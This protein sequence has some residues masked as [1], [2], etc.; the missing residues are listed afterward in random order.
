MVKTFHLNVNQLR[1]YSGLSGI[2]IHM[3]FNQKLKALIPSFY[4][5]NVLKIFGLTIYSRFLNLLF[6][7][8]SYGRWL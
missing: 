2:V 5:L 4:L 6:G 3:L 8:S 1:L 7:A